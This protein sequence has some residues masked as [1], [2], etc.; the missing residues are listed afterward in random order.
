ME[1][2]CS[3]ETSVDFQRT[4]RLCVPEDKNLPGISL[5]SVSAVCLAYLVVKFASLRE[6]SD[7]VMRVTEEELT[8][9]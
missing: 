6:L 5:L 2:T 1:A 8:R 7:S 3:S 4:T 9:I